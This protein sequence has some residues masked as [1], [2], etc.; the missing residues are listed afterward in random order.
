MSDPMT[1]RS[2]NGVQTAALAD[3][4]AEILI[5][6]VEGGASVG[7]MQALTRKVAQDFWHGVAGSVARGERTLLI[8]QDPAGTVQGTV[9]L[10]TSMPPNQ[11]HRADIA[12]M[13]VHRRARRQ[14]VAGRLLASAEQA[15]RGQGKSMLVLDTETGGQAERLYARHGWIRVGEIPNY[16]LKPDGRPCATS[17][18]YKL[19]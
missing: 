14:G 9:Q 8:A 16:A 15:A 4:L 2:L 7:F 18:F 17:Y 5:D 11:P 1:I 19:L 6:C 12:K 13:L 10:I 3:A